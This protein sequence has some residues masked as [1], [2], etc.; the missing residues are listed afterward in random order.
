MPG[1]ARAV[2][3]REVGGDLVGVRGRGAR[4]EDV[5]A[6]RRAGRIAQLADLVAQLGGRQVARREEPEAARIADRARE[7]DGRRA[8]RHRRLDDPVLEP[9]DD[10]LV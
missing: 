2:E 5:D 9:L 1:L 8:A 6:E 7:L 10:H 4:Y 3:R